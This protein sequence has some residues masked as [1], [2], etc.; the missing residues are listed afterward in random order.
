MMIEAKGVMK[1]H[2]TLEVLRGV[3]FALA[4]GEVAAIIGPSGGGKSTFLRT[5]NGLEPFHAGTIAIEGVSIPHGVDDRRDAAL[6]QS[7]RRKV[8]FVFQQFHLFPHLTVRDNIIE[9]P[10]RVGRI[11]RDEA[12]AR[13]EKLL[14]RVDL[15][16]K[17]DAY[18][19][20]LSGGQQ[21]RV[22]IARALAMEPKVILFDEPTSAL[23]PL[24]A[25][26]VSAVI[27]DLAA[28]GQ[29]MVVVTHAMALARRVAGRISVFAGGVCVE[30]GTPGRIFEAPQEAVTRAFVAHPR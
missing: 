2:G 27:T 7:I 26:E 30:S 6:L 9:A 13:A 10:L 11:S 25:A 16:S 20:Q 17:I 5:L 1:R 28:G 4:A 19:R 29:S 18:P 23:D 12:V 8:G 15:A 24:M 21:Q 3:D 22:A 14:A